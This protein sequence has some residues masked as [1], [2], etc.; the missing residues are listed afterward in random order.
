MHTKVFVG[1]LSFKTKADE[2]AAEFSA[3]GR[4]VSANIITRG[5]RSLGYGFVEMET[6]EEAQKSVTLLNKKSVDS[7][8]INVELAKPREDR[9]FQ[10]RKPFSDRGR[11]RRGGRGGGRGGSRPP[12]G[13]NNNAPAQNNNA[14][15]GPVNNAPGSSSPGPSREF[16]GRPF[17][18]RG[19]GGFRGGAGVGLRSDSNDGGR[20]GGRGGRFNRPNRDFANRTPSPT[21]LFVANLPFALDN[22]G[23]A[24]LFK[25][26][27][28]S[29]AHVVKNRSGRSK[30]FGFVEFEGEA[31]QKAAL[32][33]ADKKLVVEGRELIVKVALTSPVLPPKEAPKEG[34]SAAPSAP[35]KDSAA[36]ASP[37][38]P[39]A[40][41]SPAPAA[42]SEET[43]SS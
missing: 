28:V 35:P 18:P 13:E 31:D 21:T 10:E 12:L 2:L 11:G 36:P 26:Q 41:P 43:K 19:R 20:R 40:A 34:A 8:E 3:A 24:K 30:G 33:L 38:A 37:A 42:K 22:D 27:K 15:G 29:K 32:A 6:E 17:R 39:A 5:T 7:R 1:N 9:P 16:N 23:L 25:D 14:G 4:V